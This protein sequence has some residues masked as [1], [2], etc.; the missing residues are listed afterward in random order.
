M[1]FNYGKEKR[2][3]DNEWI[4]MKEQY[5]AE[6]MSESAI[7]EM[8]DFDRNWF[9]MRRVYAIHV[10]ISPDEIEEKN[11]D[12]KRKMFS[13]Y[14]TLSVEFDDSN[15]TGRYSWIETISDA[16][17]SANIKSLATDE[18]EL[19]T[20]IVIE[21]FSQREVSRM[22]NCSQNAIS[23]RMI[24]IRGILKKNKIF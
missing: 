20:L 21:G 7:Q 2:A 15:L 9:R 17:L 14:G 16:K 6:G 5:G 10:Q 12:L 11:I 19:L 4:V 3:F 13:K 22:L 23:K 8:Y 1:E 24:K 18:L